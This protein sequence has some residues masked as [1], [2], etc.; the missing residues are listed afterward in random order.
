MLNKK[1]IILGILVS[2]FFSII[3][4]DGYK[5]YPVALMMCP[6]LLFSF[7]VGKMCYIE[8][9]IATQQFL[10]SLPISKKDIVFEKN[11]LSYVCVILG[12]FIANV[13]SF[14]IDMIFSREFY[15]DINMIIITSIFLIIYNTIYIGLNYKYDYSKTQ[16]TP[17]IL[18][19]LMFV[20]FK[21]G[22]SILN[23]VSLSNTI[24]LTI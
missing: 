13:G 24:L 2:F 16:F 21:F 9:P 8:D 19:V 15:F 5:Y 6:S 1:N 4:I 10:L 14:I 23:A 7:I 17:Y 11:I 18:L 3:S 20:L 12:M 22:N